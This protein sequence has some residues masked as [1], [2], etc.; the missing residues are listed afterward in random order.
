LRSA[1]KIPIYSDLIHDFNKITQ[2]SGCLHRK[3]PSKPLSFI[4]EFFCCNHVSVTVLSSPIKILRILTI[5]WNTL[6]HW[7]CGHFWIWKKTR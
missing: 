2:N 5:F 3:M 6:L 4:T 7:V 1:F